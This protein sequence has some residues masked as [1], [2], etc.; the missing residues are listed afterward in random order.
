M[1]M[2]DALGSN[3]YET[4]LDS[5]SYVSMFLRTMQYEDTTERKKL[6]LA[7]YMVMGYMLV[8]IEC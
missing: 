5:N 6:L 3:T 4:H 2:N 1:Q 7:H 8:L